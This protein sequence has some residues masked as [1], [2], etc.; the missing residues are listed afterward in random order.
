MKYQYQEGDVELVF[1]VSTH[2]VVYLISKDTSC[3]PV[4]RECAKFAGGVDHLVILRGD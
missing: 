3:Y 2:N 4:R 1:T